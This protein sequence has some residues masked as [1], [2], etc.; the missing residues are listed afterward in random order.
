MLLLCKSVIAYD[1][2]KN[3]D[4]INVNV[5]EKYLISSQKK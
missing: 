1:Q 2:L 4:R 3:R 5:I